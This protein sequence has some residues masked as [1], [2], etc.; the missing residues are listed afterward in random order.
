VVDGELNFNKFNFLYAVDLAKGKRH[1]RGWNIQ[2][3][4]SL[5]FISSCRTVSIWVSA[6]L[7]FSGDYSNAQQ[8]DARSAQ[9]I[10]SSVSL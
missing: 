7:V 3:Q 10:F 5:Q 4:T 1:F 6:L 2:R 8:T 9:D